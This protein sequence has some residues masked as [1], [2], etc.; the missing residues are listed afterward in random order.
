LAHLIR[1]WNNPRSS[2]IGQDAGGFLR[3]LGEPTWICLEGQDHSRT[4][5]VT[6]L[7]H[8]NE[9]SGTRAL[10]RFLR[11]GAR[12]ATNVVALV[13]SVG[14]ALVPPGFANRMLPGCRDLNRCFADTGT[15]PDACLARAILADLRAAR[16]E[17][18]VDLHNTSGL[19][20]SYGVGTRANAEQLAL[21]ALFSGYHVLTDIRLGTLMEAAEDDWPTVTI[22]CGGARDP[23]S[24]EIAY[25]GLTRFLC[26]PELF[27]SQAAGSAVSVLRH[28]I[29]VR[30]ADGAAVSYGSEPSPEARLTM[31]RDIDRFNSSVLTEADPIG[32]AASMDALTARDGHGVELRDELLTLREGCLYARQPLRLFMATTDASI[33]AQDCLFYAVICREAD[34]AR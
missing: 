25:A 13:A 19:G 3:L 22:E 33:A 28:P 17:A 10:H 5:A 21:A 29:R 12:P 24:D 4:R 14:A 8:G 2:A 34:H 6:T 31:R 30:L 18:L 20:P 27:D 9:P 16:P 15:D 1:R 7:L 23:G 26:A 32:W 11:S